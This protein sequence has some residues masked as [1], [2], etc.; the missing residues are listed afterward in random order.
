M[1]RLHK[2]LAHAGVASRR[3]AEELIVAGQVRVNGKVVTE[4]GTQVDP[5]RDRIQV[6]GKTIHTEHKTYVVLHK[7]KGYLSDRDEAQDKPTALDLVPVRERLYAA[8][9][10]DANSE[11][12]LLLTNDGDLAHHITHPRYEH[13]KEYLALVQGKPTEE[14]LARMRHGVWYEGELLRADVVSIVRNLD[15]SVRQ[16]HWDAARRDET[17]V[18]IVLHEG[19]KRE[20]RHMSAALGYPVRRL[21]RVRI[22]PVEL[23]A[24]PVGKWRE[25]NEREVK[26]LKEASPLK[27]S[28]AQKPARAPKS[29]LRNK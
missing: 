24:L 27:T 7:P 9:R 11:G 16:Q 5:S 15:E 28:S 2:V 23:G 26:A 29:T 18:R 25:L 22:G 8:G 1:E 20:I 17:W 3:H 21:I 10:L 14:T 12:L 19:K 13:E 6:N 4:L